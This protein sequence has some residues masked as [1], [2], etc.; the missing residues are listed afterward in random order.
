MDGCEERMERESAYAGFASV[1][2][3][4]VAS[5]ESESSKLETIG[6]R[7]KKVHG[8]GVMFLGMLKDA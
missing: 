3:A 8:L 1:E 4:G 6:A 7:E 2:L 5:G